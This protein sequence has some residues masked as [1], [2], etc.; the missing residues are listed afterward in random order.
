MERVHAHCHPI[1]PGHELV[2]WVTKV[3]SYD[4]SAKAVAAELIRDV[5]SHPV[6]AGSRQMARYTEPFAL[7]VGQLAYEGKDRPELAYRFERFGK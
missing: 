6:A 2:E 3:G 5:G 4:H 1:V 7:L